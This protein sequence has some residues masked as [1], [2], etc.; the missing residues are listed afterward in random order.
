M[1]DMLI[2]ISLVD[3]NPLISTYKGVG[4]GVKRVLYSV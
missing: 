2:P 4:G 3:K 1:K